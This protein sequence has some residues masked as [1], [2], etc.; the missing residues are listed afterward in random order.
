MATL[1]QVEANRRNA[2]HSTGP[3]TTT[4]KT[5]S[6]MNALRH[7][8]Y[9]DT[10]VLSNEN[11]D[12]YNDLSQAFQDEYQ[13]VG[14]AELHTLKEMVLASWKLLRYQN[15]ELTLWELKRKLALDQAEKLPGLKTWELNAFA[16]S[17]DCHGRNEF[18]KLSLIEQRLQRS[19]YKSLDKLLQLQKLRR[20]A[21]P[22]DPAPAGQ[23]LAPVHNR[24][25]SSTQARTE[26]GRSRGPASAATTSDPEHPAPATRPQPLPPQPLTP[27]IGFVPPTSVNSELSIPSRRPKGSGDPGE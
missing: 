25:S 12:A 10:A 13:P 23:A 26:T 9:A 2:Q 15:V 3:K 14:P 8:L 6:S 20:Q 17:L 4:G 16:F 1:A 18:T 7:G 5:R 27:L 19:F 21:E 24:E 22:P 11:A